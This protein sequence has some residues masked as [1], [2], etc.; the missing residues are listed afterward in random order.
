[1]S[2][3]PLTHSDSGKDKLSFISISPDMIRSGACCGFDLFLHREGKY[4][5]YNRKGDIFTGAHR[6]KLSELKADRIYIRADQRGDY[7]YYL[8]ENLAPIL[9]DET[10]S[11][12]DRAQAWHGVSLAVTKTVF[13]KKL[14]KPL[15]KKGFNRIQSLVKASVPFFAHRDTMRHLGKMISKGY[16]LYNH[17][18]GTMVFTVIMLQTYEDMDENL[19]N[20]C[21]IGALLHDMGK[22]ALPEEIVTARK[23]ML[24]KNDRDLLRTHPMR[25]V[26]MCT[27]LPLSQDSANCILFHHEL[28]DGS[29]YPTG[30]KGEELPV[31]AGVVALCNVYD[32]LTRIT[33]DMPA[34]TP[35]D[36][37]TQI[38]GRKNAFDMDAVRRLISILSSAGMA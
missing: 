34:R 5:L 29:G 24:S 8:Q 35:F 21:G 22:L 7:E 16:G 9:N 10:I 27:T 11:R 32:N 2:N 18:V 12:V 31:Y 38:R 1:M 15:G 13:E 14:P 4:V 30:F 20:Q 36:A 23:D 26:A 28:M 25:G 6:L 19:V 37:L 3:S 33:G 17:A